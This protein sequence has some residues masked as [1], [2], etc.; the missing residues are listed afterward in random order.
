MKSNGAEL[1]VIMNTN[2]K[3]GADDKIAA[4]PTDENGPGCSKHLIDYSSVDHLFFGA[5]PV[6]TLTP[7]DSEIRFRFTPATNTPLWEGEKGALTPFGFGSARQK[8]ADT[9][10]G[11]QA[12]AVRVRSLNNA[13]TYEVRSVDE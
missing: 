5:Y 12:R 1:L 11:L 7:A 13:N 10:L 2:P 3:S 8:P 6:V 4:E 9:I